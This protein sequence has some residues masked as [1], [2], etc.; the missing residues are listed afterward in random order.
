MLE[1]N[2]FGNRCQYYKTHFLKNSN[3]TLNISKLSINNNK[4]NLNIL[5]TNNAHNI[6][7][8]IKPKIKKIKIAKCNDLTERFQ[9]PILT[10]KSNNNFLIQVNKSSGDIAN[11]IAKR[12]MDYYLNSDF[13]KDKEENI[14]IIKDFNIINHKEKKKYLKKKKIF[15]K[16]LKIC[17]QQLIS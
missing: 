7:S 6:N 16:I 14:E 1:K 10:Y 15:L 3:S 8:L 4:S 2:Y 11:E 9:R 17:N 5:L 12:K 13:K